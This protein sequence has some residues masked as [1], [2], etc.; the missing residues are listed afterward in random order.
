MESQTEQMKDLTFQADC[1]LSYPGLVHASTSYPQVWLCL[2][3][4]LPSAL[5]EPAQPTTRHP[6]ESF[7]SSPDAC[8]IS[9][10]PHV[11]QPTLWDLLSFSYLECYSDLSNPLAPPKPVCP[12]ILTAI[13]KDLLSHLSVF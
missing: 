2:P 7:Y 9:C 10:W 13:P 4:H 3:P 8:S 11:T 1:L 6:T 12:T 5:Q